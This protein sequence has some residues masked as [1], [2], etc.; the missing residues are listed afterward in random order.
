[1]KIKKPVYEMIFEYLMENYK[2]I[3]VTTPQIKFYKK[4]IYEKQITNYDGPINSERMF[5]KNPKESAKIVIE[6]A[7]SA[8]ADLVGF[9]KV[10]D[11]FVFEGVEIKHNFAVALGVEMDYDRIATVPDTPSSIEVFSKY[12]RL[13]EIAC[14]VAEFIRFLGYS[15]ISH[16]PRNFTNFHPTILHTVAGIEAGFGELGRHGLLI[17]EEF[18]PRVRL[19]TVTTDLKFPQAEKKK[20]GVDEYCKTCTLCMDTCGGGAILKE[21]K[22]IRGF[23]KYTIDP[24]KCLPYFA[25]Y[26]GCNLCVAKCAFNKRPKELRKF[27]KYLNRKI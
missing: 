18:G 10:K 21:K 4:D 24:Y 15:A 12:W 7:K 16:H 3:T 20:F 27:I 23:L 17:T 8:G 25:K 2:C 11:Y 19:A 13:G 14:K 22:E 6:F 9:T 26:D 1:M 5:F